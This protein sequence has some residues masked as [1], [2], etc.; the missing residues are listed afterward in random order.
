MGVSSRM[1]GQDQ[2]DTRRE[3][4]GTTVSFCAELLF[5]GMQTGNKDVY[6]FCVKFVCL[7]VA[8]CMLVCLPASSLLA[9]LCVCV[10]ACSS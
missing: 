3:G 4:V 5:E 1:K 10:F 2:R 7:F 8:S 9:W 6:I